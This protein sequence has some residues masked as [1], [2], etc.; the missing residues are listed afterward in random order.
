[1]T[2]ITVAKQVK[3]YLLH[4]FSGQKLKH[5]GVTFGISE[6]G[7]SLASYRL[8]LKM[9]E[10]PRLRKLVRKIRQDIAL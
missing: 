6:S 7:V 2:K 10:D 9:K 5:I 1:M 3:L 8:K 4:Q